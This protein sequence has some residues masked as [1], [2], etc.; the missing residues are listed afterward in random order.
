M[1]VRYRARAPRAVLLG[2]SR[3]QRTDLSGY[4]SDQPEGARTGTSMVPSAPAARDSQT[5]VTGRSPVRSVPVTAPRPLRPAPRLPGTSRPRSS[6][7]VRGWSHPGL[8][9]R[10][11]DALRAP[12]ASRPN[13]GRRRKSARDA[14]GRG[15]STLSVCPAA[16]W[17]PIAELATSCSKQRQRVPPIAA[18]RQR[19]QD[20]RGADP[21]GG[22]HGGQTW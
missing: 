19:C 1:P 18:V 17:V 11:S 21:I 15:V 13:G 22:R 12:G 8:S 14:C 5:R 4:R 16:S 6:R 3:R 7:S 20:G 9:P 2:R 10:F